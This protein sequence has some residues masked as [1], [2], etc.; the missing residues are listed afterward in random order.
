MVSIWFGE[1][2]FGGS[3]VIDRQWYNPTTRDYIHLEAHENP[4]GTFEVA[5]WV[6]DGNDGGSEL[7]GSLHATVKAIQEYAAIPAGYIEMPIPWD[8]TNDS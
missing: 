4:D 1:S 5:V 7:G 2:C 6:P 8:K 3:L